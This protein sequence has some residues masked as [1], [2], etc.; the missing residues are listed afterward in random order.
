[1]RKEIF[2]RI[3]VRAVDIVVRDGY[4]IDYTCDMFTR[5]NGLEPRQNE[6]LKQAVHKCLPDFE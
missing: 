4:T 3:V 2:N 5:I 6:K 1:M